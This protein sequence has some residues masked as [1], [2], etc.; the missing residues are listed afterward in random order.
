MIKGWNYKSSSLLYD[1]NISS[2]CIISLDLVGPHPTLKITFSLKKIQYPK[3]IDLKKYDIQ[4]YQLILMK[5]GNR[6]TSSIDSYER[7]E[8]ESQR[9]NVTFFTPINVVLRM[10]FVQRFFYYG[11]LGSSSIYSFMLLMLM[12]SFFT[13]SCQRYFVRRSY[14]YS[15][16]EEITRHP[17][18]NIKSTNNTYLLLIWFEFKIFYSYVNENAVK[19]YN[20]GHLNQLYNVSWK[21]SKCI[22]WGVPH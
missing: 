19:R 8:R 9:S 20:S 4:N 14:D 12:T 2:Q 3:I 16:L 17:K 22:G 11:I 6:S 7:R 10:S 5:P 21:G 15:F 13:I 1:L 18:N